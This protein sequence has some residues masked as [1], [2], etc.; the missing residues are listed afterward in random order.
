M[1]C[2]AKAILSMRNNAEVIIVPH[3]K[4]Y[5]RDMGTETS[6]YFHKNGHIDE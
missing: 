1:P 2:V 5:Y 4:T 3:L 6:M